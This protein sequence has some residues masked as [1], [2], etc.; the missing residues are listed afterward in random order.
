MIYLRF[1]MGPM[2]VGK[3]FMGPGIDQTYG[4]ITDYDMLY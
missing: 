1:L 2:R 4:Y 3:E